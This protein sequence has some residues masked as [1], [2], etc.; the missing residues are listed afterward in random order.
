MGY[1][2]FTEEQKTRANTVDLKDFLERQGERLIRSGREWRLS[3]DHSITIRGNQWFDH[4]PEE[5]GGL[6]IDFVRYYYGD[7]F[8]DAVSRLL[9]GEQ[10][11]E[12]RQSEKQKE[13]PRIPFTL[14]PANP[15]M[16]RVFAYLL[17]ERLLDREVVTAFAKEKILYE[18]LETSKD[19]SKQY[20][21]AIFVGYDPEGTARHAHK[22]GIYTM[23][24]SYRGNLASSNPCY[25]FH[26]NGKSGIIHVFEAPIDMLSY[27][28]LHKKDWQNHSYV[29]LC[30]VASQALF[31]MLKDY[32]QL[33]QVKLCLDHDI[34]GMKA[35]ERIKEQLLEAGY[36]RVEMR[37]SKWKDW[38]EDIKAMRGREAI[39]AEEQ[40]PPLMSEEHNLRLAKEKVEADIKV[41]DI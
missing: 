24:K 6:A 7:S 32:P 27:I 4:G 35:A 21:N 16:R 28:S 13:E 14:T 11:Q 30:G 20:H 37:L 15:D 18:S 25:S 33:Q 8:P 3:N 5:K 38:N 23:G 39:P 40:P 36:P 1:V 9:G 41:I 19:G 10:G 12:Y 17:K 26:W 34:P 2:Y 31:Q 29:A 22:K